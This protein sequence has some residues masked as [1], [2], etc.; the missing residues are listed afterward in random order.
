MRWGVCVCVC[1][2]AAPNL[3][4]MSMPKIFIRTACIQSQ[5]GVVVKQAVSSLG[6]LSHSSNL[7][8][9]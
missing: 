1:T 2:G 4:V 8:I 3:H 9:V 7:G 6:V 5:Y